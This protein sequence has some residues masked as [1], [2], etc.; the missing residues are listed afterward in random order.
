MFTHESRRNRPSV[1]AR[2]DSITA[3]ASPNHNNLQKSIINEVIVNGD[4]PAVIASA[5]AGTEGPIP[6]KTAKQKLARKNKLKEKSTLLLDIPDEHLLK[7]HGIKDAKIL[8]EAIKARSEGLDKTY[9]RTSV[10]DTD[11]LER[12]ISMA[13]G[14]DPN[15]GIYPLA[16]AAVEFENRRKVEW[17]GGDLYQV[18]CHWGDQYVVNMSE[19]VCSCRKWKFSRIPCK[20]AVA[21]IWNMAS[22]GLET[23]IPESYCWSQS[24]GFISKHTGLVG[25]GSQDGGVGGLKDGRGGGSQH[26]VGKSDDAEKM[27]G[28]YKRLVLKGHPYTRYFDDNM[29]ATK[30]FSQKVENERAYM[31]SCW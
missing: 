3:G 2:T 11:D 31:K 7:F 9:D 23:A 30:V 22:N 17:N 16:Y 27:F 28:K 29:V 15:N 6:P 24:R 5:S 10:D 18:N 4:A 19:R 25:G 14:V 1:P 20:H 21:T 12:W 26:E 13:F 8:W